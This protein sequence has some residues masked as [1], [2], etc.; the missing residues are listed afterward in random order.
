MSC[1][2]KCL[3]PAP[4]STIPAVLSLSLARSVF[5]AQQ[6]TMANI[7]ILKP[8][9]CFVITQ[10]HIFSPLFLHWATRSNKSKQLQTCGTRLSSLNKPTWL[11]GSN[12]KK[13]KKKRNRLWHWINLMW[14]STRLSYQLIKLIK[15]WGSF[16]RIS[17]TDW[18]AAYSKRLFW[19]K[20][21][22]F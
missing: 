4:F 15:T 21:H 1:G 3:P 14:T 18:E 20:P 22:K 13:K 11:L 8:H 12:L 2:Q 9:V 17:A 16:A 7:F 19:W 6:K 5:N 10:S